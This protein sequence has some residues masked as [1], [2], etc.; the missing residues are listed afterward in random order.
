M[1]QGRF[2]VGC[3][4]LQGYLLKVTRVFQGSLRGCFK[5]VLKVFQGSFREI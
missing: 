3:E 5:E 4:E 1:F 2:K